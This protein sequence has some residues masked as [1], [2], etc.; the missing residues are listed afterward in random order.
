[1]EEDSLV[2][3]I[4]SA[5]LIDINVIMKKIFTLVS[6]L[7]GAFL[8]CTS[9]ASA[10]VS[11]AGA[12]QGMNTFA[13][14]INTFNTTVVKALGTLFLSGAVVA[15]FFG[16]AKF[17]WG[18]R[19]G[20]E[21]AIT[22]GKQFMLWGLIAL[23]V[24]FSVY[25]II[26]F[27]Q[28]I[29]PGLNSDTITIPSVNYGGSGNGL[30][31]PSTGGGTGGLGAPSSGGGTGGLGT[32]T[33]GSGG[34]VPPATV[35]GPSTGASAGTNV[36]CTTVGEFGEVIPCPTNQSSLKANGETCSLST[37]CASAY[38]QSGPYG[39]QC[40]NDPNGISPK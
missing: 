39:S 5:T 30:G 27:A 15:F 13:G 2:V 4:F 6:C 32:P 3:Y 24:M 8:L 36:T 21:K 22:D 16:V 31:N 9:F 38:C 19:T 33:T 10:Q 18:L 1:M 29:I 26:K 34:T 17:I 40:A 35:L 12:Q 14:L 7:T 37:Q 11:V 23:F 28:N 20:V 25:G